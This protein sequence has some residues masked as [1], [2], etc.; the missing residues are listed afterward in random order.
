MGSLSAKLILVHIGD[1]GTQRTNHNIKKELIVQSRHEEGPDIQQW[2]VPMLELSTQ[3]QIN[4][5]LS[6]KYTNNPSQHQEGHDGNSGTFKCWKWESKP[7]INP[8]SLQ[9]NQR[10][11]INNNRGLDGD[12]IECLTSEGIKKYMTCMC[13]KKDMKR[14]KWDHNCT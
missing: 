10:I 2:G 4:P 13:V 8:H 14:Y 1:I 6:H 7:S 5:P 3:A 12:L 11:H 9:L